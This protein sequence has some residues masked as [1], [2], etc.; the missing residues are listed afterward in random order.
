MLNGVA[1]VAHIGLCLVTVSCRPALGLTLGVFKVCI[2]LCCA[3]GLAVARLGLRAGQGKV[4]HIAS[5]PRGA[6]AE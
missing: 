1:Y 4:K 5:S 6:C 3:L 2:A